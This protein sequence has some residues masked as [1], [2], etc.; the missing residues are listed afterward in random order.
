MQAPARPTVALIEPC[1]PPRRGMFVHWE[2]EPFGCMMLSAALARA[3]FSVRFFRQEKESDANRLAERV[4]RWDPD[5]VGISVYTA[6]FPQGARIARSSMR[7]AALSPM[8]RSPCGSHLID[9]PNNMAMLPRCAIEID[10]CPCSIGAIGS[11][12]DIT[13]SRKFCR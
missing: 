10:R 6:S 3:G 7:E 8:T 12:R 9:R 5:I 13:Q 2:Y 11:R 4:S 1:F